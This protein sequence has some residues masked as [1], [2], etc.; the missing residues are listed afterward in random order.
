MPMQRYVEQGLFKIKESSYVDG[1]GCN[2]T[3]KTTVV[4]GKGQIYFVNQFLKE[5]V[6]EKRC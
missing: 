3:T 4:T 1:N 6:L 5:N 2:V